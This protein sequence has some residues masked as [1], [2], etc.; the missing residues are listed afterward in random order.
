MKGMNNGMMVM[1]GEATPENLRKARL[2]INSMLGEDKPTGCSGCN[3]I[4]VR[5]QLL[6]KVNAEQK[7]RRDSIGSWVCDQ[8]NSLLHLAHTEG[9]DVSDC[10]TIEYDSD[11]EEITF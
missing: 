1:G 8:I 6:G 7:A 9:I 4:N 10:S 5:E 11:L 2:V 3:C